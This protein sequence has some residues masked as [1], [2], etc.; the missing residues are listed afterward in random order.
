METLGGLLYTYGLMA[1]IIFPA[2]V[3]LFTRQLSWLER[4]A[5]FVF[6]I[7][8]SWIGFVGFFVYKRLLLEPN[9]SAS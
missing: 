3:A 9:P 7:P 4:I 6:L 5:W 1:F 2:M 8:T